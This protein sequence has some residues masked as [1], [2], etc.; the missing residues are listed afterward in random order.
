MRSNGISSP[1]VYIISRR[2]HKSL[3]NDDMQSVA[4]MIYNSFGIDD[5]HGFAVI[6]SQGRT[7]CI[8]TA[9]MFSYYP[10]ATMLKTSANSA[11]VSQRPTTVIYCEKPFPV[12]AKA[13]AP[14]APALP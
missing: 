14:A 6:L 9:V 3:R 1:K 7:D 2:L 4:L 8:Y 12:S 5:M 13:S 11:T 10:K